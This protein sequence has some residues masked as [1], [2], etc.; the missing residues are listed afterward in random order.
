MAAHMKKTGWDNIPEWAIYA[1]DYG[2]EGD[3]SLNEKERAMMEEFVGRH[4][5]KGYPMSVNGGAG[6][7]FYRYPAYGEPSKTCKVLFVSP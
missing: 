4:F 2:T 3:G 1:L 5:P 7:E 6:N